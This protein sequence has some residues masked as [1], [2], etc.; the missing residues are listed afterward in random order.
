MN[1]VVIFVLLLMMMAGSS[2]AASV[3]GWVRD[4]DTQEPIVNA[5]VKFGFT[6]PIIV[7]T[8]VNGEYEIAEIAAGTYPV[9]IKA[10]HWYFWTTYNGEN[11]EIIISDG[12]NQQNFEIE[13]SH[14][15]IPVS[16]TG[17]PYAIVISSAMVDEN[18]LEVGDEVG[19]FDGDLCVGSAVFGFTADGEAHDWPNDPQPLTSWEGDPAQGLEGFT[20]GNTM[21]FMVYDS[22]TELDLDAVPNYLIGNGEFGF[23]PFAQVELTA[24]VGPAE[25][26]VEP[27]SYDYG[28][29][30]VNSTVNTLLTVRNVG[31]QP[32]L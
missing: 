23:G 30:P 17:R 27:G 28:D 32:S 13:R 20:A 5:E 10:E 22:S 19:V 15:Y 14:Y 4:L 6:D 26:S 25:I 7:H 18:I 11:P 21:E 9:T 16:P 2:L 29:V 31:G 1:R 8:D 12:L 24:T 3:G